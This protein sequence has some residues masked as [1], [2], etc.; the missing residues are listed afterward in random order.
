MDRKRTKLLFTKR[1][2]NIYQDQFGNFWLDFYF[3][4]RR[5]RKKI[6]PSYTLAQNVLRKIKVQ[7][8]E[9]RFLDIDHQPTITFKELADLYMEIYSKPNKR[10]WMDDNV[11]LKRAVQYFGD[12]R[13]SDITNQMMERYKADRIGK[14]SGAR[15]NR[16]LVCMKTVYNRGITWGKVKVNP[17]KG[18]KLFK[19]D[20]ARTRYLEKSEWEAL[21]KECPLWLLPI[22]QFAFHTGMRLGEVQ[23][24]KWADVDFKLNQVRVNMSKSGYARYIPINET[25][26]RVLAGLQRVTGNPYVF[27]GKDGGPFKR[28]GRFHKTYRNTLDRAGIKDFRFHDLRHSF[29]SQL[30]MAGVDLRTVGEILGHRSGF[31]MTMRYAHLSPEHKLNAVR[32]LDSQFGSNSTDMASDTTITPTPP[33]TI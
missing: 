26:G 9:N 1:Q 11:I 5:R 7:M 20:T 13:A 28:H 25:L 23:Y 15:I 2:R 18:V 4:G 27:P 10:S 14:V 33:T 32:K 30:T 22:V 6:G 19:E 8:A 17:V 29:A 12:V 16:E 3:Q 31:K 24:L 21:Q